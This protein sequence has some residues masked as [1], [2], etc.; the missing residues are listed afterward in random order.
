MK[1]PTAGFTLIELMIVA[2]IVSVVAG[3]AVPNLVS[4]RA[5]ANE[6]S[7]LA[8]MRTIVTAQVQCQ[9]SGVVDV[10]RDGRGEALGLAEL[11]GLR[12]LRDGALALQPPALPA[13][14]AS[15]DGAGHALARGYVMALFLPDAAGTGL[16][17][18]P[19][20]DGAVDPDLAELAWSCL[21]WPM[22]RGRTGQATFFVNQ[23]GEILVARDAPYDGVATVPPAGAALAGVA[24]TAIVGGA[25]AADTVGA[26]GN[27]WR[28]V[29]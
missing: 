12:P 29:R 8:A 6:R 26:D 24:P 18:I 17:A 2:A 15:V 3:I 7:V 1:H 11:G 13:S 28:V 5:I 14:L 4:S 23:V 16:P 10:D 22:T 20:S 25:L 9:S 19:A 21:A 27:L